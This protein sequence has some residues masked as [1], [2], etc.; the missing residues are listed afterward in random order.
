[1]SDD[2]FGD[3]G[4]HIS[5]YTQKAVEK[6]GNLVETAKI[7]TQI[8]GEEKEIDKLYRKIGETIYRKCSAGTLI[9]DESLRATIEEITKHKEQAAE[10]KKN[11][12][13]VRGMRIC[14][15]CQELISRD[16]AYC[17]HCGA[18][19]PQESEEAEDEEVNDENTVDG[20]ATTVE[21]AQTDDAAPENDE[22]PSEAAPSEDTPKEEK[23]EE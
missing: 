11:L 12:A 18:P 16:V 10:Y 2:F 13:D 9:P 3:L 20:T 4:K 15:S 8:T 14:P 6:T 19:V 23:T 7:N 22:T 1:M 17:P 21:E 5:K